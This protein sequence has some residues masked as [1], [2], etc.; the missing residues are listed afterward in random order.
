MTENNTPKNLVPDLLTGQKQQLD[1]VVQRTDTLGA[2]TVPGRINKVLHLGIDIARVDIVRNALQHVLTE[3]TPTWIDG[4][5]WNCWGEPVGTDV[6]DASTMHF[7]VPLE[8]TPKEADLLVR[9]LFQA[10]MLTPMAAQGNPSL[11]GTIATYGAT[12]DWEVEFLAWRVPMYEHEHFAEPVRIES[13]WFAQFD[14]ASMDD[15]VYDPNRYANHQESASKGKHS[16]DDSVC[17]ECGEP[18]MGDDDSIVHEDWCSKHEPDVRGCSCGMADYGAEGHEGHE[19]F[20][21]D[22]QEALLERMGEDPDDTQVA[23]IRE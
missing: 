22:T 10:G 23:F 20:D 4:D 2:I 19:D 11:N 1:L 13:V 16:F 17:S 7:L 12:D 18:P 21:E 14:V 3:G 9:V 15:L 5:G 6:N 8:V